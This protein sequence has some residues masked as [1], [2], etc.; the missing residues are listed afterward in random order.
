MATIHDSR[1]AISTE[2]LANQATITVTCNV[3]FTDVEVNAMKL[4][5]LRYTV[6]CQVFNKD[7]WQRRP[8]AVLDD[9][10]FPNPLE[11]Q[12][13]NHEQVVFN[14]DRR[15]S[16][17]HKHLMSNDELQ[18]E[19]ALRNEETGQMEAVSRTDY[20]SAYLAAGLY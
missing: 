18:A 4:L 20:V 10:T 19:V 3:E 13:S 5:G 7:L 17:L 6:R 16:D 1:L 12:V 9:L 8:V 11:A 2:P 14:S 15:M